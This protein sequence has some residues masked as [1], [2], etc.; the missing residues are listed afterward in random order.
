MEANYF[1]ILYWFCHTLT[2]I[3]HRRTCVPHPEPPSSLPPHPIPQSHP[4]A[5][6]QSALSH[7]S[8]LDWRSISHKVIYMFQC[9][10]LKSSHPHLLSTES[11]SLFFTFVSFLLSRIQ[12]HHYH[13]PN[14]HIYALIYCI[15]VVSL[16]PP[17]RL[18]SLCII[19]SSFTHF[20]RT[21]SNAF[22]L[23]AE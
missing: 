18:T 7:E 10:F 4:S 17:L 19:G 8:S 23:I 15:G 12:G 11:K 6:V 22:C 5:P 20:I 14:F 16:P 21:D 2:W 3:C 9:H 13:L 1:I